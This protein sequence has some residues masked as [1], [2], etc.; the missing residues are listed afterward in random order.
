MS[1]VEIKNVQPHDGKPL[2]KR[3]VWV[4]YPDSVK[5]GLAAENTAAA[6]FLL[7]N[8]QNLCGKGFI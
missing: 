8:M 7:I 5:M 6:W 1:E 2:V 3:S 4:V